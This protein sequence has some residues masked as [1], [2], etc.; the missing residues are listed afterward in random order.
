[1]DAIKQN[2]KY[3]YIAC[4]AL[5][6]ILV[7]FCPAVDIMGKVT[8]NGFDYAFDAEGA[9]FSRVLMF[10]FF[11][12]PLGSLFFAV[13]KKETEWGKNIFYCFVAAAAL[14]FITMIALPKGCSFAFG[15]WLG[16]LLSIGGAA[17]AYL[18][19]QNK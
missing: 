2:Q 6:F 19:S 14:G 15:A 13:A 17:V 18:T 4:A 5:A 7:A 3:I 11:V 8:M 10:L 16:L 9:G 1:M 12:A